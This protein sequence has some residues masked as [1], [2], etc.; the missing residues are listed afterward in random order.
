LHNLWYRHAGTV[1]IGAGN[2][3][4]TLFLFRSTKLDTAFPGLSPTLTRP[5]Q[6]QVS[7]KFSE[8][9]EDMQYQLSGGTASVDI[10]P[11]GNQANISLPE[12]LDDIKQ[13]PHRPSEAVELVHDQTVT[14][15]A[16]L[17]ALLQLLADGTYTANLFLENSITA[18]F[19][20]RSPLY[21]EVLL[22]R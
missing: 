11:D 12:L 2:C 6:D 1:K 8:G 16:E 15:P 3:F 17:K 7:F 10:I 19:F 21:I 20:E 14:F 18:R 13:I 22:S 9:T 4:V 5:V